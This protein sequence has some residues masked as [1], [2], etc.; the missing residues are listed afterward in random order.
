MFY[1]GDAGVPKAF[2]NNKWGNYS[3][4]VGVVLNPHGDGR[5]TIRAGVGILYNT[6]EAWFFQRL[7]SNPPVVN[8]IDLTGTQAGTFS[9]PWLNYPGGNPFPG[10][11]P[12]P[13][14]VK[15]PTSTL[16]V[17]LPPNMKPTAMTE[18]NLTYQKRLAGDWMVSG[19][20]IGNKTSHL[21][22]GYDMNAAT[23]VAGV[24]ISDITHRRPLYLA[25]PAD[26]A[27]I[28]NLLIVDDG[29]NATYNGMLVSMQHRLSH[30]FTLLS[31]YTWSHCISDGDSV[32]NIRQGYYQIQNNRRADRGS[33][34]YDVR[35]VFNTSFVYLSPAVG[36]GFAGKVLGNWQVAPILRA[37]SG[38]AINVSSGADNSGSGNS[39]LLITDRPN[40]LLPNAYMQDWG[41]STPQ[42]LNPAAFAANPSGTFGNVGRDS[43]YGP[44][45]L[46]FDL[47]L[48]RIFAFTERFQ[49]EARG[50]AFNAINHT[51]FST[52]ETRFNN[53]N[54]G[55]LTAAG[56]PRILQFALK[57]R[58]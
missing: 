37:T 38:M 43:V 4:R 52:V 24:P 25:R 6:P 30:G 41:A 58:F 27:L 20:Y 51:N 26:G 15:F 21:W 8:E 34:N 57:L 28:G 14:D 46:N 47:A 12:A 56:D 36:K 50:E 39:S 19:S 16:W 5:D 42:F 49:L 54:F 7:A 17:V 29:A 35:H 31:N 23:P 53:K 3:P 32:G 55:K 13:H 10:V 11:V 22:L 44:G 48:S 1:Y 45:Q 2:T 9:S 18:W 33:C 40:Q